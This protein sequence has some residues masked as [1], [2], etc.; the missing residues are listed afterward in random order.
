MKRILV[1]AAAA[2]AII[3]GLVVP[4]WASS[5]FSKSGH[6]ITISVTCPTNGTTATKV[7][8][9]NGNPGYAPRVRRNNGTWQQGPEVSSGKTST[10][11]QAPYV[12]AS[13][14]GVRIFWP[15]S[16]GGAQNYTFC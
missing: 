5:T 11:L 3:L 9:V 13:G 14:H 8:S 1:V 16:I 2:A 12:P 4:A 10:F 7:S 15:S 6:S